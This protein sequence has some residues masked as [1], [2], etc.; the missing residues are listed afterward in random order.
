M[1]TRTTH[2]RSDPPRPC[3]PPRYA[4]RPSGYASRPFRHAKALGDQSLV[5]AQRRQLTTPPAPRRDAQ[6]RSFATQ[7]TTT[8]SR[9]TS[10]RRAGTTPSV[11]DSSGIAPQRRN[12]P[13]DGN[14]PC[15]EPI[16]AASRSRVDR[17]RT[18]ATPRV[19]SPLDTQ[20][21]RLPLPFNGNDRTRASP[22]HAAA[23]P[24]IGDRPGVAL[25]RQQPSPDSNP[26]RTRTGVGR[27][28]LPSRSL[29]PN[30]DS[31][32]RRSLALDSQV[33]RL[34]L[35]FNGNVHRPHRTRHC[36]TAA[37]TALDGNPPVLREPAAAARHPRI[38]RCRTAATT[39]PEDT[40][41]VSAQQVGVKGEPDERSRP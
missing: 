30:D 33:R 1:T 22:Y 2:R 35:P 19:R 17:C 20:V 12:Q 11:H 34:P 31:S 14:P 3:R 40:R 26:P 6:T 21:R 16:S 10:H 13:R 25:Q 27:K 24:S 7:A 36:R 28:P 18:T 41:T 39:W 37:T 4:S 32:P 9:R 15:T 23:T 5:A 38:A 8:E 29:P